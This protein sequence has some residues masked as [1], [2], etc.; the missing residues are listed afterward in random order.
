MPIGRYLI[1]TSSFLLALLFMLDWYVPQPAA[2]PAA[3]GVDRSIIRI[4][5]DHKWPAAVPIDT[6]VRTIIPPAVAEIPSSAVSND[7]LAATPVRE[8]Y[9][10][11]PPSP[12][13]ARTTP[14]RKTRRIKSRL[15]KRSIRGR[16]IAAG[17]AEPTLAEP[18]LFSA[19]GFFGQ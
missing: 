14:K 16:Q 17:L 13:S 15:A 12:R 7:Q 1:F 18:R 6:S 8:A 10:Y 9:A 11:V 5:S 2:D 19:N 3:S 4:H